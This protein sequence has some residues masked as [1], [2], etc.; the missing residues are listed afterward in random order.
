MVDE[1]GIAYNRALELSEQLNDGEHQ[2]RLLWGLWMFQR[3][4]GE[5]AA[6][7]RTAER[8]GALAMTR[9]DPTDRLVG[10]RMIGETLHLLGFNSDAWPN[11]DR[12]IN[13][14]V[15]RDHRSSAGRFLFDSRVAARVAQARILW[16]QGYPD[17]AMSTAAAGIADARTSQHPIS[18]CYALAHAA[19]P[20]ALW[21]GD[22]VAADR[23]IKTLA[24]H[25]TGRSLLNW[26]SLGR[27]YEGELAL[28]RGDMGA[29]VQLLREGLDALERAMPGLHYGM[30]LASLALGLGRAGR[31]AEGLAM[32]A[33][34]VARAERTNEHWATAEFLRIKGEL[35][36]LQ[37]MDTAEAAAQE[38]FQ[39]SMQWADKQGARSWELRA[40]TSMARLLYRQKRCAD[41]IACLRP[42]YDRF[43]EGFGTADLISAK[44][45]LDK[46]CSQ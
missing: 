31:A 15:D 44:A 34:V 35:L 3:A 19:C 10:P 12:V 25:A 42:I 23:Y 1:T 27:C 9:P 30:I 16:L 46:L 26:Q 37:D 11:L 14:Y 45:L 40:A 38:L 17:R 20:I 18:V 2:L 21:V 6:G 13:E 7:L 24:K 43:T 5:H 32:I 36:L 8:F 33:E 22:D 4:R 41:A 39:Q 29:S 28:K